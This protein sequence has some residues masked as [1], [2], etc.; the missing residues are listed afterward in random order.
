MI[1]LNLTPEHYSALCAAAGLLSAF[2]FWFLL[3]GR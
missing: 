2:L 1:E 3:Q